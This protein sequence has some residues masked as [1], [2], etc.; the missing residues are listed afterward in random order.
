MANAL[1][2][3]EEQAI[4]AGIQ[5]EA[6]RIRKIEA[7]AQ[8]ATA[9]RFSQIYRNYPMLPPGIALNMA[10]T[11]ISDETVKKVAE[12]ISNAA[13]DNPEKMN[14]KKDGNVL[15][16]FVKGVSRLGFAA[17][18]T[19]KELI[20]NTGSRLV[21]GPV[22]FVEGLIRE[23][24]QQVQAA[25][26][27]APQQLVARNVLDEM[28]DAP[29]GESSF[30]GSTTLASLIDN[31]D[32][33]GSGWFVSDEI[34]KDQAIR[35]RAYRGTTH[36]GH[37]WTWGRGL[38]GVAFTEGSYAYNLMSGIID[39]F[40]A[41]K[42]PVLPGAGKG[43]SY[44]SELSELPQAGKGL[45]AAGK[46]AN[47]LT[48]KGTLIKVSDLT[49]DELRDARRIA[50]LIGD[51]VDPAE[52]NK[53]FGTRGGR[54]LVERLVD[55]NSYD[56]VRALVGKNV[57]ADTVKRLRDAKT[58]FEVQ[59]VL[60]DVLGV[61]GKGLTRTEYAKGVR[62]VSLTNARRTKF[63]ESLDSI[64]FGQ[65]LKQMKARTARGIGDISSENAA[66]VRD[67][68]NAMDD[69]MRT[70]LVDEGTRRSVLDQA[71]DAL[72][73]D[74]A[75]PTAREAL[76]DT[77]QEVITN[78]LKSSGINDNVVDSVFRKFYDV[79]KK[80]Q[81]WNKGADG[82]IDDAGFYNA[83]AIGGDVVTDGAFGG[84]MLA[85]ELARTVIDM[86]DP[87]QVRRLTGT[88]NGIWSK[89]GVLGR[90]ADDNLQRLEDA[91][92]L[93]LL[94]AAATYL[95]QQIFK[96]LV[97]MTG[98]Y[99]VRNLNEAQIRIALSNRSIDGAYNHP[100]SWIGWATNRKGKVDIMGEKW[101]TDTLAASMDEYR[102]ALQ[103]SK[104]AVL[105]DPGDTFRRGKRLG[106]FD[107]VQRNDPE[108]FDLVVV[109]HGD[110][111]GKL[112]ADFVARLLAEGRPEDEIIDLIRNTEEGQKW[113]RAQ[114][115]YHMGGRKVYNRQTGFYSGVKQQVDLTDD[116]NLRHL[117][118]EINTR[119]EAHTGGDAR[120]KNIISAGQLPPE[121]VV[122]RE[123]GILASDVGNVVVIKPKG[124]RKTPRQ[125][126]VVSYD[127]T[128]GEA[129]V[130]PFAFAKGEMTGDLKGL[131]RD[132][133]VFYNPN[134]APIL[135]HEVR[136][137][138]VFNQNGDL[139]AQWNDTVDQI[140]GFIYGKPSSYLDRSP[141]FRQLYYQT[142][143][144]ELLTSL[145][146]GEAQRLLDNIEQAAKRY[147]TTPQRLLGSKER[148][149]RIQDAARGNLGM[150]STLTLEEVD[151]IAKMNAVEG[152][153]QLLYDAAEQSNF[154]DAA[155]IVAPFA[156]AFIDFFKAVGRAYTVPTRSG[157]RLP[158]IASLRKTQL[159]VQSGREADPDQDGRG[160]FFIDPE[161]KE[162]SFT[163]PGSKWVIKTTTGLPGM[164]TA[165]VS[166]ALQGVDLG[167]GSVAGVRLNPGLGPWATMAA[168]TV[169][170][171]VPQEDALKRFWLPFGE[172]AFESGGP[173]LLVEPFLPAWAK[174]AW[175]MWLGSDEALGVRGNAYFDAK[176]AHAVSGQYD[177]LNPDPNIRSD[178]L[179]RLHKDSS[180]DGQWLGFL[181]FFGQFLGPSRPTLEFK[182]KA[183]QGDVF[184]N[185]AMADYR[186]WQLED[187]DT[188]TVKFLNTYGE[189]F[190]PYLARKTTSEPF[191]GLEA[192]K[193]VGKWE[194]EN[195]DLL[196]QFENVAAYF[197][198]INGQFDWQV[199]TRQVIQ[200]K[201]N[202]LRTSEAF[203]EAQ[204]FA[205]NAQ[206]R[207][208]EK[209]GL[210]EDELKDFKRELQ[211]QYPGYKFRP[212]EVGKV[213][214]QIE[215]LR[216]LAFKP[217]LDGNPAAEGLRV[218]LG[219]RDEAFAQVEKTGK[220]INAK[221][222]TDIRDT[223]KM[224]A[225][226]IAD[227]NPEFKR[228]YERVLAR[229]IEE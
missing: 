216:G 140:F 125:V 129:V 20:A 197:A 195:S 48:G 61:A 176:Q 51:T 227:S 122:A 91:G 67:T 115:A 190:W 39:G 29:T 54:R 28:P 88:L 14:G 78:S 171:Y 177:I 126:R 101:T 117:L 168:S 80:R 120:L 70:A 75:T 206:Y 118:R 83:V 7:T 152:L 148:Y 30:L 161:T 72:I 33:Q 163:Y 187:Y 139:K 138:R 57:F 110:E 53:F 9:D 58:E 141:A 198:P 154:V 50:G 133:G 175:D 79:M 134:L 164:L 4:L 229:E 22:N 209:N 26:A 165:P 62:L 145:S 52:A 157:V 208:A 64:P 100:L 226:Q 116:G 77:F 131:L 119:I 25:Q 172:P 55:A 211:E 37:A 220:S 85:S 196:A 223:L 73:G 24:S 123:V 194:E 13:L 124:L 121:T 31:W 81:A 11:R 23:G 207:Y 210:S 99:T 182:A 8:K 59:E 10:K 222:N 153:K 184:V 193:E 69:W 203:E 137:E 166:G 1:S 94:P 32:K 221:A 156:N 43:L 108:V 167:Q 142:A 160:F 158:N 112:N 204:W 36:G 105:A 65:R 192:T 44:I 84:A 212:F 106:Y 18:D 228:L 200:K 86:P 21:G 5:R 98:G 150:K 146:P 27:G 82:Q 95:Q 41:V 103:A 170:D 97:L 213:A 202:K 35:A 6:D 130:L 63:L 96:R 42:T 191:E 199:Y 40:A 173:G 76:K 109:A 219:F 71:A 47:T 185:Q 2:F 92:Q 159:V 102:D 143:V 56:D 169:L 74:T 149:G 225:Q 66:D 205:A 12:E 189:H 49:G 174:K 180:Y 15:H 132:D 215:N 135:R 179:L 147:K 128:T 183:M 113:F 89:K 181:R 90:Y 104:N 34:K 114:Q 151:E 45:V 178:E 17:F 144:D 136:M 46:V 162:W 214:E 68:I 218:Y 224:K 87:R 60:A 201:R 107:E 127:A 93:R 16:A 19:S 188:G 155:G 3:E 38:A 186:K 217:R 111:L